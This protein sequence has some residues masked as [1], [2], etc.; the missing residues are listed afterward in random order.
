MEEG[1]AEYLT[2]LPVFEKQANG[3]VARVMS[4]AQ[5]NE[6]NKGRAYGGDE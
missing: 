3:R 2:G 5:R 1:L 6:R 4:K